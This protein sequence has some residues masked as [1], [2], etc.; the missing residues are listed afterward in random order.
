MKAM[1]NTTGQSHALNGVIHLTLNEEDMELAARKSEEVMEEI[2]SRATEIGSVLEGIL[3]SP[4]D[5]LPV[6]KNSW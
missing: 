3:Q 5:K 1:L 2:W 4:H 6:N